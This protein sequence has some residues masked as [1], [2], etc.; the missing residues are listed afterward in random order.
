MPLTHNPP[1]A[2][3]FRCKDQDVPAAIVP[4]YLRAG[5]V[6]GTVA[7]LTHRIIPE[8][9]T[10][11]RTLSKDASVRKEPDLVRVNTDRGLLTRVLVVHD[12]PVIAKV[13]VYDM[14][15]S[16]VAATFP[17][18]LAFERHTDHLLR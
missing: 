11:F 10:G 16:Q 3:S 4:A 5:E 15:E 18:L 2:F 17:A 13:C 6:D 9:G 8:E 12:K 7:F 14:D 1:D